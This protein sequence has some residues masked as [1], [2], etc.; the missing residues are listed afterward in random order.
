MPLQMKPKHRKRIE[1][2]R[3]REGEREGEEWDKSGDTVAWTVNK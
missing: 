3:K 1:K 2:K